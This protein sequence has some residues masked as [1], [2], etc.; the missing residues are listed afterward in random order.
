MDKL[1]DGSTYAF[2]KITTENIESTEK[3]RALYVFE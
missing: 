3:I 1:K 2:P